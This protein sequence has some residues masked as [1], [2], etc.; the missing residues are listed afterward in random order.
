M[1]LVYISAKENS[2]YSGV[3]RKIKCQIEGLSRAGIETELIECDEMPRWKKAL[4]FGSRSFDWNKIEIADN[5]D[6]IYVRYQLCDFQ[7]IRAL[8]K[9][10]KRIP[11]VHIILEI[12]TYPYLKEL[13]EMSNALTIFRDQLYSRFLHLYVERMVTYTAQ[14]SLYKVK[15]IPMV[16][17]ID[18]EKVKKKN[19]KPLENSNNVNVIAVARVNFSHG[20]DRFLAGLKEYYESSCKNKNVIFHLVG[21]GEIV[22]QLKQY[23]NENDL[24][25][26]V[27]FY[28][29]KSGKELDD[30]YDMADVGLDVL[31]GHRKGDLWFGTLKSREYL[32]KGL[33]FIT[34]YEVPEEVKDVE[35]YILKVPSDE[36]AINIETVIKFVESYQKLDYSTDMRTFA[37]RYCDVSIVMKPLVEYL[38]KT[39]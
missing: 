23:V 33:P 16:N 28:G 7:F 25:E 34:E 26:Y 35:K 18:V 8:R 39:E 21:D 14:S 15:T 29:Y 37:K 20:Y 30:L 27:I 10:K 38:K 4:P 11:N 3:Y 1:K 31:G 12:P 6:V 9:W 32:S 19:K 22:S 24:G 2:K 36:S 5:V 13:Q 17:G